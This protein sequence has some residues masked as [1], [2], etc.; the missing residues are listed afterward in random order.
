MSPD[1]YM[2]SLDL[3]DAYYSI[4]VMKEHRKYLRFLFNG[5]L[6]QFTCLPNGL[7]SCPRKFTKTLKPILTT[8]HKDGHIA[9]GYLDD[10]YLQG[11][12][13]ND[14][15]RNII[16]TLKLFIKLGFIIHPTKSIFV[17]SKEIKMLGF[18]LNSTTMTVHLTPEKKESIKSYCIE[19][20]E[21]QIFTIREIAKVIGKL[22]ASFPGVMY[23][24]LYYRQLEKEK[25]LALKFNKGD[26]DASM[27]LSTAARKELQWWVE[28]I[29][30]ALKPVSPGKPK[31]TITTDASP[32]GWGAECGGVCTGGH[33]SAS[34]GD[35][36]INPLEL[37]AI[38]LGL[39]T[40]SKQLRNTHIR[41][42]TDNTTALASVNHMGTSHSNKCN[43]LAK[44]IWEW[45]INRA[46]WLSAA[47]IAGKHNVIADKESRRELRQS[48]WM[49]N[50]EVLKDSLKKL[51]F[52]PDIDLF[53]SRINKQYEK[54]VSYR[55]DPNAIAINAFSLDWANLK[56]YAFPPFSVISSV[57]S[58]M[59][60]DQAEGICI[61][62]DW[63]TQAWYP[64]ATHLMKQKPIILKPRE[65]LLHLPSHPKEVHPLHQK[66]QLLVCHLS[67]KN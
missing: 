35:Q 25:I 38:G 16:N 49:I 64:K 55:P 14:C 8:L 1:C 30:T 62:P 53:A 3:K 12:N 51:N 9:S 23:G 2:A 61:L 42:R 29:D 13:Y 31:V 57:L 46:I 44:Q 4:P 48:E 27:K 52:K 37:L 19:L 21:K 28:N 33:W 36:H 18:I 66:L 56:F 26:F 47:H 5:R 6:Y 15:L 39:K 45:C 65:N 50:K 17:P 34:E 40:F 20:L 22:V 7:S 67:G 43:F 41:I 58:K 54:Y 32:I 24:P 11:K 10:I 63:P 60:M 59:E